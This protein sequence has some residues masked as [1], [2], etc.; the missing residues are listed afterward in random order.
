MLGRQS[1]QVSWCNMSLHF[2][3]DGFAWIL[4]AVVAW[5]I[6]RARY[7]S[8]QSGNWPVVEGT[9]QSGEAI[10]RDSH[11]SN[12][13]EPRLPSHGFRLQLER[14]RSKLHGSIRLTV[15]A[16]EAVDVPKW[17]QELNARIVMVRYDPRN[18]AIC[19]LTETELL[20]RRIYQRPDWLG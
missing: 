13:C 17:H 16:L 11:N 10:V 20:S 5:T 12:S 14:G 18:P 4:L 6:V 7:Q 8:Q 9:I 19:F 15:Y 1:F 2:F 3:L